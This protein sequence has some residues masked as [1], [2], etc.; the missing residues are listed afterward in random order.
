VDGPTLAL[1]RLTQ[2]GRLDLGPVGLG[3]AV[4]YRALVA[5]GGAQV[6]VSGGPEL[7]LALGLG[8]RLPR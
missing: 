7:T 6:I 1:R 3:A 8:G 4:A 5:D 2:S